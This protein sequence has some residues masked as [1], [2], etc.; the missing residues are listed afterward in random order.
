MTFTREQQKEAY[1]KLPAEVQDFIMDNEISDLTDNLLREIELSEEQ[2]IDAD[3]EILYTMYGL[4]TLSDAINNIATLSGKNIE[5]LSELK[6]NLERNIFDNIAKIES[7]IPV[8]NINFE[9]KK[10]T[11]SNVGESF[12]QIILNQAKA[13]QPARPAGYVPQNLPTEKQEVKTEEPHAIHN[14]I[15]ESDPYREPIQ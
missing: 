3:S 10:E 1:K 6:L 13:M 4:Q 8:T 5:Q 9:Q 14:Y 15:G 11:S 12:E 7:G 2:S